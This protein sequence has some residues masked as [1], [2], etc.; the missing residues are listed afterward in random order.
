[1]TELTVLT[2]PK[3][4]STL[5]PVIN[6]GGSQD[7]ETCRACGGECCQ[8][9]PGVTLPSDLGPAETLADEIARRLC[10]GLWIL[11]VGFCD[12]RPGY[13]KR[14]AKRGKADI[15]A[16]AVYWIRP[17]QITSAG[18]VIDPAGR[19]APCALWEVD[20]GCRLEFS[21]RPHQCRTLVPN[22]ADPWKGCRPERMHSMQYYALAWLPFQD[23]VF[24][25]LA[26]T[27]FGKG[28]GQLLIDVLKFV[29]EL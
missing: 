28:G 8:H 2:E 29:A 3:S 4:S 11:D 15:E 5:L 16:R 1:M 20:R 19:S 13:M 18:R 22:P 6:S 9:F 7:A 10:S 24:K 25:G 12:P 23:E 14:R 26:A 27:E 17:A 21:E